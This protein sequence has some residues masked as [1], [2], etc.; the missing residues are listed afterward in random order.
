MIDFTND[1]GGRLDAGYRGDA[2]DCVVRALTIITGEDY[3]DIYREIARANQRHEGKRSARNGVKP[4]VYLPVFAAHGLRKVSLPK[5]P[6]PTY[7]EAWE[8]YG[9]C[10]V[11]TS[12]HVAAIIGGALRDTFDGRTYERARAVCSECR[13]PD[14]ILCGSGWAKCS[15][16]G[17]TGYV[18]WVNERHE[19]KAQSVWVRT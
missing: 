3:R 15:G 4:K 17:V 5:G 7:T 12:R 10:I 1:D 6:R 8:R 2:G 11:S 14:A 18:C 9:D 13:D 19:R 16:C